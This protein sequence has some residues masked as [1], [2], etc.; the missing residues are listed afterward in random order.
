MIG[1]YAHSHG[2][3]HCNY[4]QIFA[5]FLGRDL[6]VFTDRD[7]C[8]DYDVNVVRLPNENPDGSQFDRDI[9]K[10]PSSLHYAPVNMRKITERNETILKTIIERNIKLLIID[11][12]VEV[13]MLARVSSIPYAYVR[14]QG[15][16]NDLPHINA[17]EGSTFLIAYFPK[18]MESNKTPDWVKSKT[19]YLGFISKYMFE[20]TSVRR[21][22]KY[23]SNGKPNLLYLS[24]FGGTKTIDFSSIG[25]FYN[26]YVVG[27][28]SVCSVCSIYAH[29]GVVECTRAF[30]VHADIIVAGCG[31]NTTSEILALGKRFIAIVE[32]RHYDEQ[33]M[34]AEGLQR[35]GWAIELKKFWTMETAIADLQT[36]EPM[37]T[38]IPKYDSLKSFFSILSDRNFRADRVVD[39]YRNFMNEYDESRSIHNKNPFSNMAS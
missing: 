23:C 19:I 18:E 9:F 27:P 11:V 37:S 25:Q 5:R 21:P 32:D 39:L 20:S 15:D 6:V 33:K 16:R 7:Y 24:G 1:Y 29:I 34:M 12:S 31:S 4:A 13:A 30:I 36:L 28:G 8:F 3:G 22:S 38:S 10:E 26:I 14:L 35:N 17:F 2:S